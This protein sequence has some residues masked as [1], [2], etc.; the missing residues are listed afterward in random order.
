[1]SALIP[2]I[3]VVGC[4]LLASVAVGAADLRFL[5]GV[6]IPGMA[7][8][9]FLGGIIIRVLKWAKAPVPYRIPTT[10]GQQKALTW[11]A[12]D[13]LDNPSGTPGV[14]GRMALEIL[15]FRSLF[16][17]TNAEVHSDA[18]KVSHVGT[19]VLWAA[20]MVFHWSML[21]VV[22]R[23]F[24]LFVEPV[25]RW[26]EILQSL[27]GFFQIG[28]PVMFATTV[29]MIAAVLFLLARR[30][31][32]TKV[33]FI[34]LPTDYFALYLLLGIAVSG[35]YMRHF[36]KV[37]VVQIKEAIAGWASFSF[38]T[39]TG[40]GVM[41]FVHVF[42]VSVLLVYFPFSKLMHAPGVFLSPTRNLANNNRVR[43]HINP[44]NPEIVGH[45]YAEWEEEFR[46]KLEA[47]GYELEGK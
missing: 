6:V 45:T 20:A 28:V 5:F 39:P 14:I 35:A 44:W 18:E 47:S 33:R 21:I 34:S 40:V 13:E 30:L 42:L 11:M 27:D 38:V 25:P 3:I 4:A 46:D 24:R 23:H 12:H 43:R 10:A 1:M 41:Y 2:L 26:V 37:D 32:D 7:F 15:F 17:N 16:R 8:A 22:A 29:A 9:V 19:Q 36:S 31:I